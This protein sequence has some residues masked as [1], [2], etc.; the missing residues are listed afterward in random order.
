MK[1]RVIKFRV[2]DNVDYMSSPFTLQDLQDKKI[3]F[4]EQC[5][6]M[7]FIGLKDSKRTEEYPDGQNIFEGDI[8]DF[9]SE[10]TYHASQNIPAHSIVKY[11]AAEGIYQNTAAF[12]MESIHAVKK[13]DGKIMKTIDSLNDSYCKEVVVIGNI[14]QNPELLGN[15]TCNEI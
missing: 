8:L 9:I 7:Q 11:G 15:N 2:W 10:G 13:Y 4:T 3:Q 12:I 1:E 5:V 14:Y 6:L